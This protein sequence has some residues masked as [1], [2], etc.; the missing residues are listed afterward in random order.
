MCVCSVRSQWSLFCQYQK[1]GLV[2]TFSAW[3]IRTLSSKDESLKS[4]DGA[5]ILRVMLFLSTV[6]SATTFAFSISFA[7][8]RAHHDELREEEE[9]DASAAAQQLG[10]SGNASL[11][12]AEEAFTKR[13]ETEQLLGVAALRFLVLAA[14]RSLATERLMS[15]PHGI[16]VAEA[17][18][19]PHGGGVTSCVCFTRTKVMSIVGAVGS[20]PLIISQA[21]ERRGWG[22]RASCLLPQQTS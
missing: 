17:T 11:R 22:L 16:L 20:A 8:M 12:D 1:D 13:D 21:A 3:D 4:E 5:T 15:S 10:L 9:L 19:G 7:F 14:L 18:A 6:L 2:Q